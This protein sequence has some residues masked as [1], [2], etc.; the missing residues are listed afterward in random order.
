MTNASFDV[1]IIHDII[2]E[3]KENFNLAIDASS[4]PEGVNVGNPDQA[5]LTILDDDGK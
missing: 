3:G 1:L 4:L 5:T 2:S